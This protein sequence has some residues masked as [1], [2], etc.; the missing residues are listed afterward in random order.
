MNK[1]FFFC[2]LI[3]LLSACKDKSSDS[4]DMNSSI[5][6][7]AVEELNKNPEKYNGKTITVMGEVKYSKVKDGKTTFTLFEGGFDENKYKSNDIF[8]VSTNH[9]APQ[10]GSWVAVTGEY[11]V[12][13]IVSAIFADEI[14]DVFS[15]VK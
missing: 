6:R 9:P 10:E 2:C 8:I 12:Q 1:S 11:K 3:F 5:G 13:G 14:V 15:Q 7:I 4:L